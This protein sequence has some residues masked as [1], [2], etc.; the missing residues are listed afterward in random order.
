MKTL[1]LNN[2]LELDEA[3]ALTSRLNGDGHAKPATAEDWLPLILEVGISQSAPDEVR[4]LFEV[5]RAAMA[6]GL[7]YVPL[8]ALSVEQLFRVVEAAILHRSRMVG[9]R[10]NQVKYQ[11]NVNFLIQE[12][13]IPETDRQKW[14]S[15]RKARD[16][17]SHPKQQMTVNPAI[18]IHIL[19]AVAERINSL[20]DGA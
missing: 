14:D 15:F 16:E 12:G 10:P 5:A 17:A 18:A 8:Q 20:F 13:I 1:S 4:D 3:I 7:L 2:W 11:R 6:Y 9:A 19:R